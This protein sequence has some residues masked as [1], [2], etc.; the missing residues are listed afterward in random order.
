[1]VQRPEQLGPAE[2]AAVYAAGV[3]RA[4]LEDAVHVCANFSIIVRI[5]DAFAFHV[6]SDAEFVASARQLLE[7]GYR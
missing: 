3:S 4:A 2:V 1:M 7:R 6:P 5:A